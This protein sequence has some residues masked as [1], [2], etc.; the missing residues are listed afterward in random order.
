M[1]GNI[2]KSCDNLIKDEEKN[3]SGF[4][5]DKQ[6]YNN[7]MYQNSKSFIPTLKKKS[8]PLLNEEFMKTTL[9]KTTIRNDDIVPISPKVE[10]DEKEIN[11]IIYNYRIRLII[12]SFRKLKRMKE[13]AHELVEIRKNLKEKKETLIVEGDEYI[14]VDLFPEEQYNY[15]GNIFNNK[16]DGFGIQ[17]FPESSAKYVGKFLNG[18]R[19]GYCIFEDKS[20]FYIYKGE[21]LNN[22][23]G[24]YGI[25]Y[26]YTKEIKY[27]GNWLNN[28]KDGI[29][30]EIYKNGSKYQGEHKKGVK[31]G[32]GTYYW[33][34][35]SIYEG[36]WKNN[37]MDGY[38]IYKFKDG[39]I[40]SGFWKNNQMNGFGK[41]T[42]PEIKCYIGFFQKDFKSGFGLIFWFKEKKA[43]MGFWK[44]NKQDGLGKFINDEKIRYGSWKEGS[45]EAKYDENKFFNLLNEENSCR[46]FSNIFQ[47]DYDG[48]KEYIHTFDFF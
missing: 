33:E 19:I 28:R 26:D 39:S 11:K 32:I 38:G 2:C 9:V 27:E 20:K 36:Q 17:Y 30:I 25:F 14:D 43:F 16:K 15:L 1:G 37:L 8:S 45:R 12:S 23:T 40:C 31:Q 21:A 42:F 34:D 48:L 7:P 13:E 22:F 47:M 10:V 29:G 35:G 6:N 41:F 24:L 5:I 46:F 3:L 18:K 4:I 44:N